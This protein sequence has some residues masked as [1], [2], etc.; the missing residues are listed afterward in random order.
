MDLIKL[1]GPSLEFACSIIGCDVHCS[2][3]IIIILFNYTL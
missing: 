2:V 3:I 1:N